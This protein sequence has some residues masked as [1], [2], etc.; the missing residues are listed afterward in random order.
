MTPRF[1]NLI[2]VE[3]KTPE[4]VASNLKVKRWVYK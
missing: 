1:K 2:D 3:Q 4:E